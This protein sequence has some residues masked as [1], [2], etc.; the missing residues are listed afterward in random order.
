VTP[1]RIVDLSTADG[2]F[3][4]FENKDKKIVRV[5]EII[6]VSVRDLNTRPWQKKPADKKRNGYPF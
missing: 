1:S 4:Y 2:R 6:L 3:R 5:E